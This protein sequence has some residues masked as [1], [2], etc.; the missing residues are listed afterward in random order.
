MDSSSFF[1]IVESMTTSPSGEMEAV[2]AVERGKSV[3]R[4]RPRNRRRIFMAIVCTVDV[5]VRVV[6][7]LLR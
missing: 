7:V 5:G 6:N 3:I 2:L 1:G 4:T